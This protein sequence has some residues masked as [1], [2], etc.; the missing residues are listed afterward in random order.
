MSLNNAYFSSAKIFL[1]L[2]QHIKMSKC[3]ICCVKL[4]LIRGRYVRRYRE[5][6]FTSV[7]TREPS[8]SKKPATYASEN[9]SSSTSHGIVFINIFYHINKDST[10]MSW[11][12]LADYSA[13]RQL[14]SQ[15]HRWGSGSHLP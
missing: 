13:R 5:D 14:L 8:P 11:I 6:C 2:T 3:R 7:A 15:F 1:K 9:F 4:I 12:L 10:V